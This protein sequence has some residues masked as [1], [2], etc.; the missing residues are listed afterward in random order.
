MFFPEYLDAKPYTTTDVPS[1]NHCDWL[2]NC[3]TGIPLYVNS[4]EFQK[5]AVFRCARALQGSEWGSGLEL[6][7]LPQSL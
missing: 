3:P 4:V 6:L 2:E 7:L 1:P 5:Y